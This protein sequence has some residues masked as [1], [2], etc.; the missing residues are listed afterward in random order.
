MSETEISKSPDDAYKPDPDDPLDNVQE[1]PAD[2]ADQS[3][4]DRILVEIR[5]TRDDIRV[6]M[7]PKTRF[8]VVLMPAFVGCLIT[9]F[10][11]DLA[12]SH[13]YAVSKGED[14][15]GDLAS[16]GFNIEVE[17][18]A[19]LF[20]GGLVYLTKSQAQNY[21]TYAFHHF[22]LAH[23]VGNSI[24]LIIAM[25]LLEQ[26]YGAFRLLVLG[27]SSAFSGSLISWLVYRGQNKILCGASAIAYGYLGTFIGDM[28]VEWEHYRQRLIWVTLLVLGTII[29]IIIEAVA[30]P[31]VSAVAHASGVVTCVLM[32]IVILP[33]FNLPVYK[34]LIQ[35]ICAFLIVC[36]FLIIPLCI[37]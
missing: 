5:R 23:I 19:S 17:V 3:L 37:A 8:P 24:L 33:G 13:L 36:E 14:Y 9:V 30:L 12:L 27:L 11:F 2:P 28:I 22:N 7:D 4:T 21:I 25:F 26:R 6:W 10:L 20:W 1:N 15:L 16:R 31:D 35:G 34:R 32:S 29:S 18:L